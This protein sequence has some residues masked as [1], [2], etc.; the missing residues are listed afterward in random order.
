MAGTDGLV[1]WYLS[2]ID[3]LATDGIVGINSIN[4]TGWCEVDDLA[5]FAH[6]EKTIVS[7]EARKPAAQ[8]S[9]R[10]ETMR[11]NAI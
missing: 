6:A 11:V 1:R 8:L 5:D 4:G 3:E 9:T 2:A 7:W 10:A